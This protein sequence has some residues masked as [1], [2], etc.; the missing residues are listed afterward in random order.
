VV[1]EELVQVAIA[2]AARVSTNFLPNKFSSLIIDGIATAA[3]SKVIQRTDD[4][5]A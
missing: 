4:F 5:L 1:L 3:A 2:I